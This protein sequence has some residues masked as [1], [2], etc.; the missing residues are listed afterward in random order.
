MKA[1]SSILGRQL[2]VYVV[3][4]ILAVFLVE[5]DQVREKRKNYLLGIFYNGYF[6]NCRDGESYV[7]YMKRVFPQDT[8]YQR[9]LKDCPH[10]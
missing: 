6:Q 7:S 9:Y 1:L 8:S 5:W 10:L 4:I 3:L 2:I